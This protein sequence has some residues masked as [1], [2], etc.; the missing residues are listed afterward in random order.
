M[1]LFAVTYSCLQRSLIRS[2]YTR[3]NSFMFFI[4]DIFWSTLI[5]RL[6]LVVD[7]PL[8]KVSNDPHLWH[9]VLTPPPKYLLLTL[10][11]LSVL[12][13]LSLKILLLTLMHLAL[14]ILL[15]LSLKLL[16][17]KPVTLFSFIALLFL[18]TLPLYI[19]DVSV[20]EVQNLGNIEKN[21]EG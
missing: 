13:L 3:L 6:N 19:F 21:E 14:S 10:V 4:I 15:L 2:S 5:L 1:R 16:L 11:A 17:L 12:L 7:S 9:L 20:F 8:S 18:L